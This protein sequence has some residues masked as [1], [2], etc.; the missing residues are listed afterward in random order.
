VGAVGTAAPGLLETDAA[1]GRHG[2]VFVGFM[3]AGKSTAAALAAGALGEPELDTDRL[4]EQDLG[5]AIES[6]FDREG[7]AA[8]RAREEELVLRV[9]AR[10]D[11]GVVALGGGALGS[12]RV[13][14]A[15]RGHVVVWLDVG[16]EEAWRRVAGGE[17]PL[18]RDR[19][20]FER[21]HAER[22][23]VYAAAADAVVG[24]EAPPEAIL[25]AL[26]AVVALREE[27]SRRGGPLRLVWARSASGDYPVYFG[28]GALARGVFHPA[29]GRRFVVADESVAALHALPGD[30]SASVPSGETEKTLTRAEEL[31]RAMA[32]AGVSREDLVVAF[33][34]GVVGDLAGFCAA[35]YHRGVRCAQVPTTV[36]AQVDSAY[37]GKTGVD[38]PEAKNY[39]GAYHQPAAVLVDPGV[40]AT[41]PR[42][43]VAAGYAEVVKTA[44]IAG[45][46]LWERVRSGADPMDEEAIVGC[47]RTKLEVVA[48]DERDEGR[49]Q[50]LNL[51]HT[52]GHALEAATGYRH[53][54]HGEAVALGMLCALRLSG[55]DA[56][57]EEVAA[58]LSAQGLPARLDGVTT[59]EAVALVARDKKRRRGS[60]PFVLVSGPG[61]VSPGHPVAEADLRAAVAEVVGG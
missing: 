18:A 52:V 3:G 10:P 48:E 51:G 29:A 61:A 8:F 24:A 53:L 37:G 15:L 13:R 5:E 55:Q 34:G 17:R 36:V 23:P 1:V 40:L 47:L 11:A 38:L 16:A 39:V 31:L 12:E 44:L 41:L 33:G 50:V 58:L 7:E 35:V 26:P 42:E 56:L 19:E 20:R 59:E 21:L 45:G 28:R 60:V 43:E 30:W 6:F 46:P 57:R 27:L 32:R 54:R 25:A 22:R 49:R 9:L 2:I 14:A 4:L